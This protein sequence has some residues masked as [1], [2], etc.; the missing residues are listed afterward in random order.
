MRRE[1]SVTGSGRRRIA[2]SGINPRHTAILAVLCEAG[3]ALSTTEIRLRLNRGCRTPLV[4]E[5]V[6]RVLLALQQADLVRRVQV[7]GTRNAFWAAHAD[8]ARAVAG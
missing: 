8:G 3:E 5:Q 2:S 4:A 6:Y 1:M 7:D